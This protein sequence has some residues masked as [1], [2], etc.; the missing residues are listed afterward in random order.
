MKKGCYNSPFLNRYSIDLLSKTCKNVLWINHYLL[1]STILIID[2]NLAR[3]SHPRKVSRE[4]F[5]EIILFLF[6]KVR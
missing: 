6:D 2:L 3:I 5:F 1:T 4:R